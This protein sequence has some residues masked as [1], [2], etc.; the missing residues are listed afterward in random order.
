[1]SGSYSAQS[2]RERSRALE[3]LIER[4]EHHDAAHRR[5]RRRHGYCD[6][7]G[8]LAALNLIYEQYSADVI[9]RL[10]DRCRDERIERLDAMYR[11]E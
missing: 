7:C 1:M 11:G 8:A 4:A 2:K 5:D 6:E 3:I 10:C 9:A